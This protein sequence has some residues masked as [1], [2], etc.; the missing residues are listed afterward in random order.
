MAWMLACMS[1]QDGAGLR[2]GEPAFAPNVPDYEKFLQGRFVYERHCVT[3]HGLKGDGKGD[4]AREMFPKPRPF[5]DGIFKY[6]STPAGKLP[7]NADLERIIRHGIA[8]TSMPMF[9]AL[10][11]RDVQAVAEY[12]K[13]FS[14][15]WRKEENFA[16]PLPV[17]DPPDWFDDM[18]AIRKH[19][20]LGK[21]LFMT[22]CVPCH[23]EKGEGDGPAV[24]TLVDAWNNP[25]IPANLRSGHLR[26]GETPRD[27]QRVLMKGIDG[28]PMASFQETLSESQRWELVAYLQ[29]LRMEAQTA[30]KPR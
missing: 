12:V 6:T 24:A 5:K 11:T 16:P 13:S 21:G 18:T 26:N 14:P 9:T 22:T 4:M 25:A 3:C 23:G 28:T 29:H 19:A 15:R 2:A 30:G 17:P 1:W 27:M 7:T 8:G 20:E 10:T